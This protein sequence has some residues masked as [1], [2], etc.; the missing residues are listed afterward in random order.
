M[1]VVRGLWQRMRLRRQI[2]NW[3]LS[4]ETK[5]KLAEGLP[6]TAALGNPVDVIGDAPCKSLSSCGQYAS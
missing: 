1:L 5:K 6:E 2:F 4:E 3:F